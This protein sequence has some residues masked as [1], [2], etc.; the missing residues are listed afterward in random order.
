MQVIPSQP[1]LE[2]KVCPTCGYKMKAFEGSPNP[3]WY[4]SGNLFKHQRCPKCGDLMRNQ[5]LR[6]RCRELKD[7]G[8]EVKLRNYGMT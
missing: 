7:M 4:P 3:P 5:N 8:C 6:Q 1:R 2:I